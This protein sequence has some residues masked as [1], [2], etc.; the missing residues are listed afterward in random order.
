L[1]N[2]KKSKTD[3]RGEHPPVLSHKVTCA[4]FLAL[5]EKQPVVELHYCQ[6]G[7]K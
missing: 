5:I 7:S 2:Q 3:A 1:T 6:K 4:L